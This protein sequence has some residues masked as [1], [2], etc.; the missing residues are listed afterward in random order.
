MVKTYNFKILVPHLKYSKSLEFP[1]V[2]KFSF[3]SLLGSP[4][5]WNEVVWNLKYLRFEMLI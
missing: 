3:C 4:H 2:M 1:D 5:F